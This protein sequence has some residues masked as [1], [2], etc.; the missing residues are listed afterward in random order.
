MDHE[1][2][3]SLSS[4]SSNRKLADPARKQFPL[5]LPGGESFGPIPCC[6]ARIRLFHRAVMASPFIR[7]ALRFNRR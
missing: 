6:S 2:L 4:L 5:L 3:R 7:R 1:S